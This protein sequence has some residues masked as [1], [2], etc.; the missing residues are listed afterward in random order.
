MFLPTADTLAPY[1]I[2][3]MQKPQDFVLLMIPIELLRCLPIRLIRQ[4]HCYVLS[5]IQGICG[6]SLR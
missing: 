4:N 2:G 3:S 5:L 6:I 1:A